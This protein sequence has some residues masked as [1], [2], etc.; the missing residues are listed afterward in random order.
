VKLKRSGLLGMLSYLADKAEDSFLSV[1]T[2]P[3]LT[4]LMALLASISYGISKVPADDLALA[5]L[6]LQDFTRCS[7]S[8][9]GRV[10]VTEE[11]RYGALGLGYRL[12]DP[13]VGTSLWILIQIAKGLDRCVRERARG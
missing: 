2:D 4:R 9:L 13:D 5:Q 6:S 10:D 12:G 7:V 8:A 11:R 3:A 1:A